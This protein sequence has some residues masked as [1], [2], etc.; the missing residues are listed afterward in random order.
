MDE[1]PKHLRFKFAVQ[2]LGID[3]EV[4]FSLTWNGIF[5]FF[6]EVFSCLEL[7]Q[8]NKKG[9][10]QELLHNEKGE[11]PQ[12]SLRF[13]SGTETLIGPCLSLSLSLD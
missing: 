10:E 6:E 13:K 4:N 12:N 3:Q 9:K 8:S 5:L 2:A 11:T 1:K 7:S